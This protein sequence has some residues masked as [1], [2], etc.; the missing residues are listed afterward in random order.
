MPAHC[1]KGDA[2]GLRQLSGPM[3]PLPQ[4]VDDPPA[5]RIGERGERPVDAWRAQ[6]SRANLKPV[7]CSISCLETSRT[8]CENVQ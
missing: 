5:M 6:L 3:G 8:G 7:A 1:R 4:E 2:R